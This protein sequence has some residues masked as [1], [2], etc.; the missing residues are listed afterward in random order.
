ML[1]IIS[2]RDFD[3]NFPYTVCE[4]LKE[5]DSGVRVVVVDYDLIDFVDLAVWTSN[6]DVRVIVVDDAYCQLVARKCFEL[7]VYLYLFDQEL[8]MDHLNAVLSLLNRKYNIF[9]EVLCD[10]EFRRLTVGGESIV[11]PRKEYNIFKYLYSNLGLICDQGDILTDVLG[12]HAD[13]ETRLVSV[14]VRFLRKRLV[15]TCVEIETV[16]KQGYRMKLLVG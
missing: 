7:D 5:L 13:C 8:L 2:E 4:G 15:G 3:L 10:D 9:Y 16:R 6:F 11:L 12:Y 1:Q 14:Y